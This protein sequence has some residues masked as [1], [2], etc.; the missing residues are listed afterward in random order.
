MRRGV[1]RD[2]ASGS[3]RGLCRF[4]GRTRVTAVQVRGRWQR[5]PRGTL[6]THAAVTE[7]RHQG[8][9]Q[10]ALRRWFRRARIPLRWIP[11]RPT[12]AELR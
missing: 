3:A 6:L 10:V 12:G 1:P 2:F 7:L 5:T 4:D 11:P 9:Q 8:V